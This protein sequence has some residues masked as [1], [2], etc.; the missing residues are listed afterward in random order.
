MVIFLVD[1]LLTHDCQLTNWLSY[2]VTWWQWEKL[3]FNLSKWNKSKWLTYIWFKYLF[4][5]SVL[6][7]R[8]TPRETMKYSFFF[9]YTLPYFKLQKQV[10]KLLPNHYK[11]FNTS[12]LSIIEIYLLSLRSAFLNTWLTLLAWHLL[13]EKDHF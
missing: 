3:L 11:Y 2:Q 4:L 6:C 9:S 8:W 13:K 5:S 10:R 12:M 7:T 1:A